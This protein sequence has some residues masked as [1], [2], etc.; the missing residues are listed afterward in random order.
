MCYFRLSTSGDFPN[1]T[2][3]DSDEN[4]VYIIGETST[5]NKVKNA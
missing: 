5:V 1:D 4:Y 2:A 3:I